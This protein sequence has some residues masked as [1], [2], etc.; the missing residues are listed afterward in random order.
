LKKVPN[1]NGRKGGPLH[2]ELIE[3]VRNHIKSLDLISRTEYHVRTPGGK[4]QS[5]F[6]DIVAL[7]SKNKPVAYFQ[8]GRMT[9][10]LSLI[11]RELD[12]LTDLYRYGTSKYILLLCR[13]IREQYNGISNKVLYITRR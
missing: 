9:K 1:Q 12:A 13:T 6:V 3:K 4:K 10:K 5:R 7:D 8:V 11:S 2:Q